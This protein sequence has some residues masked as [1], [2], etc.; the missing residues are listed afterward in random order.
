MGVL[1]FYFFRLIGTFSLCGD[2]FVLL[3][4]LLGLYP[5]PHPTNISA[6]AHALY[7]FY[8][9]DNHVL[10]VYFSLRTICLMTSTRE[11]RSMVES[12]CCRSWHWNM[13]LPG[14]AWKY[15]YRA[16]YCVLVLQIYLYEKFNYVLYKRHK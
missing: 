1:F 7:N 9:D 16:D 4:D 13:M 12:L 15:K 5:T 10:R 6:G 11:G 8:K 14:D 3:V 2:L